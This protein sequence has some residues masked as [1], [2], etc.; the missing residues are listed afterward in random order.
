MAQLAPPSWWFSRLGVLANL[1]D[2]YCHVTDS[3]IH[4]YFLFRC[5]NGLLS[6]ILIAEGYSGHGVDVRARTS[7]TDYPEC[8]QAH[9]HVHAFDPTV[10]LPSPSL[11][12]S[13]DDPFLR[14]GVFIIGNHADELTPWVPVLSTLHSGSGY[15]SIPCCAW[16]FDMR[17]E[18]SSTAA[19]P[20]PTP[21]FVDMLNL[22][23]EG[24]RSSS[25]PMYHIWL[26]SQRVLRTESGMRDAENS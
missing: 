13:K 16:T 8:T 2:Q 21:D 15:L 6:H 1:S 22:G 26:A 20:I 24:S 25:Y 4:T 10:W 11:S 23:G 7:W 5:G 9:L 12:A 18:R 3:I 19:S 14:G 17:Y